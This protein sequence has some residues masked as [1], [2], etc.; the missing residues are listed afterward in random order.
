LRE[1]GSIREV[2]NVYPHKRGQRT[3]RQQTVLTR[4]SDLQDRL[5]SILA[6][7]RPQKRVLGQPPPARNHL[8]NHK[9]EKRLAIT[10]KLGRGGSLRPLRGKGVQSTIRAVLTQQR[11]AGATGFRFR[12]E[13]AAE[14]GKMK[15]E[16]PKGGRPKKGAKPGK[17]Y[18][19]LRKRPRLRRP[20]PA[21]SAQTGVGPPAR[22]C[23]PCARGC[24]ARAGRR[25]HPAVI[26]FF[27]VGKCPATEILSAVAQT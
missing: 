3:P 10:C 18:S 11:R 16:Q 26:L 21:P 20:A 6:L 25:R 13:Y 19:R 9:L 8:R 27:P 5:L 4:T 17:K 2:V 23:R 15:A 1:L 24:G 22:E 14:V 12:A 7:H